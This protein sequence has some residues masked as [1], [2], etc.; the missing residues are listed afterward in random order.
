MAAKKDLLAALLA[1]AG[2]HVQGDL[3]PVDKLCLQLAERIRDRATDQ[4]LVPFGKGDLRKSLQAPD[5]VSLMAH[6]MARVGSNLPYARA[7]HDGRPALTIKPNVSKNPPYGFRKH[8]D[9]KRARLKFKVGNNI[10]FAKQV[11]QPA[12]K[13]NPWLLQAGREVISGDLSWLLQSMAEDIS[14]EQ[15]QAL[16]KQIKLD[17]KI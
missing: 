4:D 2:S 8:T 16:V 17:L 6:G 14:T 11:H 10:I 9:P 12:R 7:V 15:L 3:L 1:K 13:G 5:A